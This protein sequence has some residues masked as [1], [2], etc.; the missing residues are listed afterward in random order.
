MEHQSYLINGHNYTIMK[1]LLDV[2][3]QFIRKNLNI[4]IDICGEVWGVIF[5]FL[6]T[7]KKEDINERFIQYHAIDDLDILFFIDFIVII[8]IEHLMRYV[9]T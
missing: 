7:K 3:F 5:V 2:Q 8:A 6:F 9:W 4:N 1:R